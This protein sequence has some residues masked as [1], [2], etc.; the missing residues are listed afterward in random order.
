MIPEISQW[1]CLTPEKVRRQ[2]PRRDDFIALIFSYLDEFNRDVP[3]DKRLE[4]TAD[5]V[6]LGEG[7]L[8]DSFQLIVFLTGLE[9][10]LTGLTETP[11][12]LLDRDLLASERNPL[13]TIGAL[14]DFLADAC[15]TEATLGR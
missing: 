7:G 2:M 14:A 1:V 9:A 10:K 3:A 12:R 8:L 4:K 15:H 5:T 13:A 6:L 11:V